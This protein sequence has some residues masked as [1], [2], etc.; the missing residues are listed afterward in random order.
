MATWC[1]GI[2]GACA[3]I[4]QSN[5]YSDCI[6]LSLNSVFYLQIYRCSSIYIYNI[7]AWYNAMYHACGPVTQDFRI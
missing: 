4:P 1:V 2:V 6:V 7:Y 3:F 5:E